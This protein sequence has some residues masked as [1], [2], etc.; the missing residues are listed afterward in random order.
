MSAV[1]GTNDYFYKVII[2][3]KERRIREHD[4]IAAR[5]LERYKRHSQAS[6]DLKKEV[7][8]L[9]MKLTDRALK[10]AAVL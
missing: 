6:T 9:E 10:K 3:G 5:A 1:E 7:L 4:G 8:E 2:E